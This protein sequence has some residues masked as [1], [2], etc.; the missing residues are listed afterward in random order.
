MGDAR[1]SV[2]VG[3]DKNRDQLI[4]SPPELS[5]RR[6]RN[7]WERRSCYAVS[8]KCSCWTVRGMVDL[9]ILEYGQNILNI[10]RSMAA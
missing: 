3:D 4:P 1:D 10:E 6:E 5:A 8:G 7:D 9:H 2:S